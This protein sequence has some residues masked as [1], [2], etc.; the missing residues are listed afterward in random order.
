LRHLV[1]SWDEE[2]CEDNLWGLPT[3][4]SEDG[5]GVKVYHTSFQTQSVLLFLIELSE[6]EVLHVI[7]QANKEVK[8]I[9]DRQA[10][11]K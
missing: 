7:K 4:N 1:H 3:L 5:R 9:R 8:L 11:G 10:F 2:I 6:Y